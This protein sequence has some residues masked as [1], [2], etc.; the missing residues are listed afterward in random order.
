[1]GIEDS[2]QSRDKHFNYASEPMAHEHPT[3]LIGGMELALTELSIR[4]QNLERERGEDTDIYN[5]YDHFVDVIRTAYKGLKP[6]AT[7]NQQNVAYYSVRDV[8]SMIDTEEGI[9]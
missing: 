2:Q 1:M 8:L 5:E 6:D 3:G 7:V 4:V 9:E